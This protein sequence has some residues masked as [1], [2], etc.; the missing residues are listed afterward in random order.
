MVANKAENNNSAQKPA[1]AVGCNMR[2][3]EVL[4]DA[5]NI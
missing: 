2:L 1:I 5:F 4:G 3:L